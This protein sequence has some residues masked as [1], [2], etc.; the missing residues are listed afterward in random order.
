[1]ASATAPRTTAHQRMDADVQT[2]RVLN[3]D[4]L[5]FDE[6]AARGFV[7]HCYARANNLAAAANHDLAG[8]RWADD[9]RAALST[10]PTQRSATSATSPASP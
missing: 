7:E 9:R 8:R 6:P 2:W 3:G 1:M 4:A 10:I 5:P